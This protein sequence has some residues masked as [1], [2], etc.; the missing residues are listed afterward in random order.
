MNKILIIDD[1]PNLLAVLNE[2]FSDGGFETM[3][4]AQSNEVFDVIEAFGPDII[5]IDY[6]LAGINGGEIC[7]QIKSSIKYRHIP[8]A[9]L[10]AYPKVFLSLGSY[11]CDLFVAK[12]FDLYSLTQKIHQLISTKQFSGH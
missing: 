12:P 10:S 7:S 1:D 5:L 6:L 2:W 9:I 11:N 8:I 4:L 3:A